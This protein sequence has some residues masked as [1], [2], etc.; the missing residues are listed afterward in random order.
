MDWAYDSN[1]MRRTWANQDVE[2]VIPVKKNRTQP[3]LHDAEQYQW[4]E[5]GNASSTKSHSFAVLPPAMTN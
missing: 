3:I 5:K 4:R 1:H 2:A